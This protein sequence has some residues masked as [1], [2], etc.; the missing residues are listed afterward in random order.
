MIAIRLRTE[1]LRNPLGIDLQHPRLF[2]NC[3]GGIRQTAYQ[4]ACDQWDSGKVPSSSM[5]ADY[6]LD[7]ADRERV[8][9][10]VRLWDENDQPGEWSGEAFFEMGIS[11][12]KAQWITGDY[13]VNKKRR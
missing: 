11:G 6:L 10:R 3:E 7:L 13:R 8:T 4:I 5:H 2:W 12:W 1:Y 9:W